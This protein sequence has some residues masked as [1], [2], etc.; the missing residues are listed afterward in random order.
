MAGAKRRRRYV[1][2]QEA[3]AAA[4]ILG[5]EHIEFYRQPDGGL[6]ANRRLIEIVAEAD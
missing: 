4:A 3:K 5:I 2:K 1:A 6:R